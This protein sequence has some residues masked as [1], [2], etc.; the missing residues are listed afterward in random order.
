LPRR[1]DLPRL[2]GRIVGEGPLPQGTPDLVVQGARRRVCRQGG[3]DVRSACGGPCGPVRLAFAGAGDLASGNRR[4][5]L[6][7]AGGALVAKYLTSGEETLAIDFAGSGLSAAGH[8]GPAGRAAARVAVS[9]LSH[10]AEGRAEALA[11]DR[12]GARCARRH[13]SLWAVEAPWPKA[14]S[15]PASW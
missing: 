13:R 8:G 6:E 1:T 2:V 5:A 7:R 4:A 11:Q 12:G 14:W 15:S 9:R 3:A 10:Q